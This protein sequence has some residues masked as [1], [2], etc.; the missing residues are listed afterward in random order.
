LVLRLKLFLEVLEGVGMAL[1]SANSNGIAIPSLNN[2]GPN[3]TEVV[4]DFKSAIEGD[5]PKILS[6]NVKLK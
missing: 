2:I 3:L 5:N 1:T 6:N 4:K